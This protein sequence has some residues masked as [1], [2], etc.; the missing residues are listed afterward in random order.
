MQVNVAG[1]YTVSQEL[2][3][4]LKGKLSGS[5]KLLPES[6]SR[7]VGYTRA[8]HI[9]FWTSD[10][11]KER[12]K[13]SLDSPKKTVPFSVVTRAVDRKN[14]GMDIS[15]DE[16]SL[17]SLVLPKE[18]KLDFDDVSD[19]VNFVEVWSLRKKFMSSDVLYLLLGIQREPGTG[20]KTSRKNQ[21][22]DQETSG[23]S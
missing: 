4:L 7:V 16:S 15:M 1:T 2:A 22:V 11:S 6:L 21:V 17:P 3:Y 8:E 19:H 18:E 5:V 9:D 20:S 12:R 13:S 10:K 14:R 23:Q